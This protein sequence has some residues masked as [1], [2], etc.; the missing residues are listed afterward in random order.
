MNDTMYAGA[1]LLTD[2]IFRSF[3]QRVSHQI[4]EF[5]LSGKIDFHT[6]SLAVPELDCLIHFLGGDF[7]FDPFDYSFSGFH[8]ET[9]IRR[10]VSAIACGVCRV[11]IN[12]IGLRKLRRVCGRF[13][14]L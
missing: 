4:S 5:A 2:Y 8:C 6:G 3:I 13:E 1:A 9:D 14:R 7:P 11:W 12:L 10:V